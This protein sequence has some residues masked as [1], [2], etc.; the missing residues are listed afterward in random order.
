MDA[1]VMKLAG[2]NQQDEWQV[3][4]RPVREPVRQL[5]NGEFE[6]FSGNDHVKLIVPELSTHPISFILENGIE[7]GFEGFY[8]LQVATTSPNQPRPG[9]SGSMLLKYGEDVWHPVGLVF[10]SAEFNSRT[11]VCV[12]SWDDVRRWIKSA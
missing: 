12:F 7:Y 5:D 9:H 11:F 1:A 10:G 6:Y 8:M 2:F 4:G 3:L